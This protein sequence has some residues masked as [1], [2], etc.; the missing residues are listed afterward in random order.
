M[1][2]HDQFIGIT[3]VENRDL[4][5]DE[6]LSR[7][8]ENV[9]PDASGLKNEM[10]SRKIKLYLGIDATSPYLHIGHT[11]PLRKLRQFQLL[12]HDVYLLFGGFTSEIG[13]PSDKTA[14]RKKLTPEDVSRNM[15]TYLTQAGKILDL[16]ETAKN[17]I[18]IVNNKE[19]L[20]PLNFRNI[21]DL[22]SN[23]SVQQIEERDMY[24]K[25]REES[26]PIWLH[27]FL[28]I[29]MQSYDASHLDVDLEVGGNDQTFNMLAG[30]TLVRRLNGHE[31]WVMGM[32]LITDKSG[33][34]MGKSEGNALNILDYP[35]WK[36]ESLMLWPDNSIPQTL[37]SL[38]TVGMETIDEIEKSLPEI[39]DGRSDVN[40]VDLKKAVSYKVIQELDGKEAADFSID[41]FERVKQNGEMPRR[42]MEVAC[43]SGLNLQSILISS[44][45]AENIE[46]ANLKIRGGSVFVD[47]KQVRQN[48]IWSNGLSYVSIGKRTIRN[49][50]KINL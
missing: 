29:L 1:K 37:R 36:M 11:V 24:K 34:K 27:E 38:T 25:R 6:V 19:W 43:E 44:Q 42:V 21:V 26:K 15:A 3:E 8:V 5:V 40:I 9:L 49:I 35:A 31:K 48:I 33:K 12:G 47:G 45:L 32:K 39:I 23:F 7:G 50:R 30:Q 46:D 28:Y 41:E 16:S 17:P 20:E 22:A 18:K 13:D 4:N 2:D 14:A 10:L